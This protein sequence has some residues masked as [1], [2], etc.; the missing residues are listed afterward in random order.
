VNVEEIRA[1]ADILG[2]RY[3]NDP[4]VAAIEAFCRDRCEALARLDSRA[5]E[6]SHQQE[7]NRVF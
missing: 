4:G 2:V 3:P 7:P 1:I 6:S 5:G